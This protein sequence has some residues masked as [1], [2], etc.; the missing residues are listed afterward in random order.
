MTWVVRCIANSWRKIP[1][2]R[3][4]SY[5]VHADTTP[6]NRA[7][8]PFSELARLLQCLG[9]AA[10]QAAPRFRIQEVSMFKSDIGRTIAAI[11][12]T[13]VFSATCVAG[14]VG[15]AATHHAATVSAARQTA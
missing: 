15:P 2:V 4:R 9:Q 10:K 1:M 11:A 14:A 3:K 5:V 8:Q 12:C 13:I 6:E 7:N